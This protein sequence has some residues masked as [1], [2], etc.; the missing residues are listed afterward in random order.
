MEKKDLELILNSLPTLTWNSLKLNS[1]VFK[2]SIDLNGRGE[3]IIHNIPSGVI[4][5][6]E[7]CDGCERGRD[8]VEA[9]SGAQPRLKPS[10]FKEMKTGMGPEAKNFF[11]KYCHETLSIRAMC[12]ASADKP[13]KI[14]YL[15]GN[16]DGYVVKQNITAEA[17]SNLTV[18]M[19][20]SGRPEDSGFFGIQTQIFAAEDSVVNIIKLE[21]LGRNYTH[22]ENIGGVVGDNARVNVIQMIL[23]GGK[24]Y[25]GLNMELSGYRSSFEGNVGYLCLND[26]KLDMNYYMGHSGRR[27]TS[28]LRVE[29]ALRDSASKTFR[30]T[31][32]LK[33]GAKGACGDEQEGTLLL[34]KDVRNKTLPVILCDEDDVEGTHGASI[35]RL[36]A[37]LLFY[38]QS[39]GISEKEA[40]LLMTKAKLNTVRSLIKDE[41]SIGKV[42]HY[43]EEAFG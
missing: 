43:M 18:I 34:S 35:G 11:N 29:G 24:S 15:P 2:D 17:G 40:E 4:I 39:R 33:H 26:Q 42:Q 28:S 6:S 41:S 32:D 12:T 9:I 25:V 38:M 31:I 23:G 1:T 14:N 5:G 21:L 8:A 16:E 7:G 19:D 27:S 3:C 10:L 13:L 37:E 20:Y 30:G 22:F 36:S